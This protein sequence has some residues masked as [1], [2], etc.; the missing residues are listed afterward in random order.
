MSPIP[1]PDI[2]LPR[3]RDSLSSWPQFHCQNAWHAPSS[4]GSTAHLHPYPYW[5]WWGETD[6]FPTLSVQPKRNVCFK[7][8]DFLTTNFRL[9][10]SEATTK[11]I[12]SNFV[13]KNKRQKHSQ[14]WVRPSEPDHCV[15]SRSSK[16]KHLCSHPREWEAHIPWVGSRKLSVAGSQDWVMLPHQST[17]KW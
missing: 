5:Q 8:P 10:C 15:C 16:V 3:L 12:S 11:N 6:N 1:A 13:T 7:K 17:E 14:V 4:L 9:A 2:L